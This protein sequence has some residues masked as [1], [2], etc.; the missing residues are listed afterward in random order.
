MKVFNL[1][2]AFL[3]TII[4]TSCA[5][6][7]SIASYNAGDI[8]KYHY[9]V[10]GDDSGGDRGLDDVFIAVQNEISMTKLQVI[11]WQ[12]G[13]S[14]IT[15]GEYVLSPSIYIKNEPWFGGQTY[16]SISFYDYDTDQNVVV[17]QSQGIGSTISHEKRIVVRA[18]RKELRKV[19]GKK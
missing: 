16:I 9:V 6:S 11:S 19:F 18:I 12:E 4:S 10:L 7:K 8:S 17:L 1:C 15:H 5:T 2:A 14:K 13:L 3:L